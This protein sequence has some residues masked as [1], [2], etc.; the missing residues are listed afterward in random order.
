MERLPDIFLYAVWTSVI[1][2]AAL[3]IYFLYGLLKS[4]DFK[5][6]ARI[7]STKISVVIA[8]RNEEQGIRACLASVAK[9]HYSPKLF[10]VIVVDDFSD[11]RTGEIVRRFTGAYPGFRFMPAEQEHL[12]GK[13][14]AIT[15]G[16]QCASGQLIVTTDGDCIVPENWLRTLAFFYENSKSRMILAPVFFQG[17]RTLFEKMQSLEFTGLMGITEASA[18]LVCPVICNGANLAYEKQV[19]DELNGFSGNSGISSGD[20]VMLMHKIKQKY[21]GSVRFLSAGE[22]AVHTGA[23]KDLPSFFSQRHRWAS[24][25]K[26]YTDPFSLFVSVLVFT[27]NL[28]VLLS[29]PFSLAGSGKQG[30]FLCLIPFGIKCLVDFLFLFLAARKWGR[31]NLLKYFFPTEF[32]VIFYTAVIPFFTFSDYTWKGR[33]VK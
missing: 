11:D 8:V 26:N 13:K 22:A 3:L 18:R 2:Y 23:Q 21:P 30:V 29:V 16:I 10:E 32:L 6:Q 15:R 7:P 9:Q 28:T 17:E 19:F 24:K 12:A 4:R 1:L 31:L 33:N 5:P 27:T 20:D 14:N 25:A